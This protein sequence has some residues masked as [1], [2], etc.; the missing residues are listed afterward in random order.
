MSQQFYQKFLSFFSGFII[1]LFMFVAAAEFLF[2]YSSTGN[3]LF[4][5]S[6][7]LILGVSCLYGFRYYL[8]FRGFKETLAQGLYFPNS[9]NEKALNPVSKPLNM[10][11]EDLPLKACLLYRNFHSFDYVSKA[12]KLGHGEQARREL[13]KGLDI[14]L[15]EH[16]EKVVST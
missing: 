13:I 9:N 5:Y 11:V 16:K 10:E 3:I 4:Y 14:L 2:F 7:L 8:S 15:K 1:L 6:Y 12:L